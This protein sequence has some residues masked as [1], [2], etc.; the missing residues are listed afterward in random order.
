[1]RVT[2]IGNSGSGKSTLAG[3]L[4]QRF[5]L[6]VLD[7]DTVAWEPGKVAVLRAHSVAIAELEAFCGAGHRW[8]VEGCYAGLAS[9][10]LRHRPLLLFLEPGVEACLENCR[11]R[12]WEP[13]KYP[14]LAEQDARLDALLSW[15]RE[16]YT[17]QEDLSL[18]AHQGLF[19]RY[20]GPK[21]K[22]G[23][24]VSADLLETVAGLAGGEGGG[25]C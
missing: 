14:S 2:V 12:P 3:R 4:A 13:H 9:E 22:V 19:E 8:V 10:T 7:L 1:M 17:R 6:A 11:Q 25:G 16:Y 15:V 18:A 20:A 24:P 21:L 23:A 5:D